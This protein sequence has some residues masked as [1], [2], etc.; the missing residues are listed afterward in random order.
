MR[1]WKGRTENRHDSQTERN[2]VTSVLV[3]RRS[4]INS[5][6]S[7]GRSDHC[8]RPMLIILFC[9]VLY[10]YCFVSFSLRVF[11]KSLLLC[12]FIILVAE[13]EGKRLIICSLLCDHVRYH[14][15]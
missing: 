6:S 10:L 15:Q 2:R 3:W 14:L 9:I 13:T 7:L 4:A 8:A 12:N 5:K 11:S 1:F